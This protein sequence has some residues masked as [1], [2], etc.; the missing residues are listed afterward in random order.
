MNTACANPPT[1]A[2]RR[3]AS[4]EHVESSTNQLAAIVG[5]DQDRMS[6][7]A[8]AMAVVL[9]Q[10]YV[11]LLV[12]ASS[13]HGSHPWMLVLTV[14]VSSAFLLCCMEWLFVAPLREKTRKAIQGLVL[15]RHHTRQLIEYD[16]MTGIHN[17]RAL[18]ERFGS[19]FTEARHAGSD[20]CVLMVDIDWFK[21]INDKYGHLTGDVAIQRVAALLKKHVRKADLVAR[22]G[23]EEFCLVLP[24]TS[25]VDALLYAEGIRDA[26][27]TSVFAD[28]KRE[29]HLTVSIGVSALARVTRGASDLI[30]DADEALYIAKQAGRNCV[31]VKAMYPLRGGDVSSYSMWSAPAHHSKC[32]AVRQTS[33]V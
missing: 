8:F 28:G 31:R 2:F 9:A 26:V 23:G 22:Y 25:L 30:R 17:R 5:Q 13:D 20:L 32:S 15:Y 29:F 14:I 18:E 19:L 1:L 24:G 7:S 6:S 16:Q 4:T 27:E 10:A 33:E 21:N 12:T 3:N 11:V